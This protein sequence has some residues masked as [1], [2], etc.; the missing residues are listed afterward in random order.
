MK[1][2]TMKRILNAVWEYLESVKGGGLFSARW[3]LPLAFIFAI[4]PLG[5]VRHLFRGIEAGDWAYAVLVA[6]TITML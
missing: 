1:I 4:M 3:S 6:T 5:M 2:N